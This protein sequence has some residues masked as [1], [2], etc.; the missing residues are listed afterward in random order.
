VLGWLTNLFTSKPTSPTTSRAVWI[1]RAKYDAA[2]TSED[3]R[4]HWA[5][6]D[7]LSANAANRPE[8]RRVLRTVRGMKSL[9]TVTPAAS[10]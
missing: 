3:N 7:G 9:T 10:Y 1:V 6:A 5:N 2:T 8:A 4:R